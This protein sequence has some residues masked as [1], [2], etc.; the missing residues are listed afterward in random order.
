MAP[1][2]RDTT[3]CEVLLVTE[4]GSQQENKW[5]LAPEQWFSKHFSN[6]SESC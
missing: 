2:Q 4:P 5:S 6:V 1:G 3:A